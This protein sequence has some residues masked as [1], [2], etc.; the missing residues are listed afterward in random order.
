MTVKYLGTY[1]TQGQIGVNPAE[2]TVI[3]EWPVPQKLKDV[4]SFLSMI[5]F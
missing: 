1:L 2:V 4:E 3:N 5:D